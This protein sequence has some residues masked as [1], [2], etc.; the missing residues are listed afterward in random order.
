[1]LH[2]ENQGCSMLK[3]FTLGA[4]EIRHQDDQTQ[5]QCRNLRRLAQFMVH[6]SIQANA[7]ALF[8]TFLMDIGD[9]AKRDLMACPA[10]NIISL[11]V[12]YSS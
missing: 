8:D 12:V 4:F 1:M 11:I 5:L 6:P 9:C 2:L 7:P 3:L 10:V